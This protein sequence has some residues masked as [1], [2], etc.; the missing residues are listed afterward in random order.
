[1]QGCVAGSRA[2]LGLLL[3]CLHL[4]GLFARS[5][6]VVED[7]VPQ[8]LG[9]NLPLLGQPSLTGPS[10]SEH[11]RSKPGPGDNDLAR[12]LLKPNTSPSDGSQPAGGSGFQGWPPSEGLPSVDSWPSEDPWQMTAAGAEDHVG[13]VLPEE[14]SFL[15][16][17]VALPLGEGFLPAGSSAHSAGPSPEASLFHRDPQS[18]QPPRSNV[19]GTQGESLAQRPPWSL[20]NRIQQSLRPGHPW[21]TLSPSVSWGGGGPGTGWGTRPMPHPVGIWGINNRY[22]GASWGNINRYPGTSWG[23]I[24][25]YPG[26]SWGNSNWYPGTRWGN[27]HLHPGINNQFP[28]RVLHPPGALWNSPA[29]FSSPQN[30][31]SQWG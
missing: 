7:K 26:T 25:Q 23:N 11:R 30:A 22:P 13:E 18:R 6:G 3:V 16:R 9:T 2:P 12:V 10:N 27:I 5:I 8:D 28:P 24:N 29:H 31:G 4:S 1:M 17:A 15:S 19:L 21:G 14:L 20:I